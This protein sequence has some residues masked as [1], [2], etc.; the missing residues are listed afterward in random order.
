M[1]DRPIDKLGFNQWR[2]RYEACLR[3]EA[4]QVRAA[5]ENTME[6]FAFCKSAWERQRTLEARIVAEGF[7][8]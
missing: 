5:L 1:I 3:K 2:G 6:M 7:A 8:A 4:S